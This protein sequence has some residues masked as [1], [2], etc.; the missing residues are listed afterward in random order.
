MR[1]CTALKRPTEYMIFKKLK[2]KT[3]EKIL[4][5]KYIHSRVFILNKKKLK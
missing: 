1:F 5:L 2:H 3:Q 4:Q